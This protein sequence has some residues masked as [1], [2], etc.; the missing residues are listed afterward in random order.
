M[1]NRGWYPSKARGNPWKSGQ[2]QP[3]TPAA[4]HW[5]RGE[6]IIHLSTKKKL[7]FVVT[8]SQRYSTVWQTET[9]RRDNK[10]TIIFYRH[11]V[12]T[13]LIYIFN[14]LHSK[15]DNVTTW[16]Q[17]IKHREKETTYAFSDCFI[18]RSNTIRVWADRIRM[19][20][21]RL[22]VSEN[23]IRILA[24]NYNDYWKHKKEKR[25]SLLSIQQWFNDKKNEKTFN[26]EWLKVIKTS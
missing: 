22:I 12:I 3:P 4:P 18:V 10:V 21:D 1:R 5:K 2:Y 19:S 23:A 15:C 6:S 11:T 13:H 26:R 8:L 20:A 14:K 24:D 7:F 16:Q 9:Y 25:Y 17:K